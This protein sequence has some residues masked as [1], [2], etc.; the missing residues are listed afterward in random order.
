[1]I[2]LLSLLCIITQGVADDVRPD[3]PPALIKVSLAQVHMGV[4]IRIVLYAGDEEH[5]E[6]AMRAAFRRIAELDAKLSDYKQDSELMQLC[7]NAVVGEPVNVSDD[8]FDVL[9][10]AEVVSRQTDGAFDVTVGPVVRLWRAARKE[11]ALPCK[12][13]R[14]EA[15]GRVGWK[16]VELDAKAK[17]VTLKH[18]DMQ[19]DLGGIAKGYACDTAPEVLRKQGIDSAMIDA[20]GD[21]VVGSAPPGREGWVI[22]IEPLFRKGAEPVT[23]LQLANVAI[24]TSGDAYQFV[25]LNGKR[26][27]HIVDPKTGVGLTL[28]SSVTV[29]APNATMADAWASA[30]SVLGPEE[31]IKAI[32]A[33]ENMA[34]LVLSAN[35]AT[36]EQVESNRLQS[37]LFD[38]Y[39]FT[40]ETE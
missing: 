8:L 33:Q 15:V 7:A 29:I 17:S 39:L 34:A 3:K 37:S 20:G 14:I 38:D 30:V 24:A 4:P 12:V 26:Y 18:A 13:A 31:G 40:A 28:R 6:A 22:A 21:L 23:Y 25:E 9:Q 10:R 32:D 36:S 1:M 27:S 16:Y 5:G 19:L 2:V 35:D 11:K